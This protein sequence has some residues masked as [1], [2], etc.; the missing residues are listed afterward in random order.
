M[1][2]TKAQISLSIRGLI[3]AFVV[4]CLDSIISLDSTAANFES[5]ASFCGCGGRFVSGLVGNSQETHYLVTRLIYSH[6]EGSKMWLCFL[7]LHQVPYEPIHEKTWLWGFRSGMTQTGLLSYRDE[8]EAWNFGFSKSRY[9]TI[10]AANN[11]GNVQTAQMRRLICP[12]VVHIWHKQ[13][14]SWCGS[15]Y[16]GEQQRFWR[17]CL[18]YVI[19]TLFSCTDS[20]QHLTKS[21]VF[22]YLTLWE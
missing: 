11:I 21:I 4:R 12:F 13:V 16:V 10:Q 2:T 20:F 5:L 15:Y 6:S 8:L 1:R 17:D 19:S 22:L 3:S 7:K 9:Y 14:F 18:W